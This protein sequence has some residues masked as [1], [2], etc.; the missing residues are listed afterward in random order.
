M[1]TKTKTKYII[2]VFTIFIAVAISQAFPPGLTFFGGTIILILLIS[3]GSFNTVVD[4]QGNLT[5]SFLNYDY[6][7]LKKMVNHSRYTYI[8]NQQSLHNYKLI[9]DIILKDYTSLPPSYNQFMYLNDIE[10]YHTSYI[11]QLYFLMI[12]NT[13][14]FL[15]LKKVDNRTRNKVLEDNIKTKKPGEMYSNR[16]YFSI[17][18]T[19]LTDIY[20]LYVNN[21]NFDNIESIKYKDHVYN[22][23]KEKALYYY[24]ENTEQLDKQHEYWKNS[25]YIYDEF[26]DEQQYV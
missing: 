14:T 12:N 1:K 11:Y 9:I 5:K 18:L 7:T 23:I 16:K 25:T 24:L 20:N 4:Y 21:Y 22:Y 6:N 2:G 10:K 17:D 26:M 15:N 8:F 19:V 3:T 13:N